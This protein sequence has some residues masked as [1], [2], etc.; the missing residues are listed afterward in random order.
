MLPLDYQ[1]YSSSRYVL[2]NY[3]VWICTAYKLVACTASSWNLV[4]T[5]LKKM[6][7]FSAQS[8]TL[9]PL[10]VKR[11]QPN[12][13]IFFTHFF[14]Q[15]WKRYKIQI[16]PGNAEYFKR[17]KIHGITFGIL[18]LKNQFQPDF[19]NNFFTRVVRTHLTLKA[20][21]TCFL[22]YHNKFL[23]TNLFDWSTDNLDG[24]NNSFHLFTTNL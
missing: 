24:E 14:H 13:A 17:F 23:L 22:S 9:S 5:L 3:L 21:N 11:F 20:I 15:Q 12:F 7:A 4:I 6:Y 2:I 1:F 10:K 18:W 19:T 8:D 16:K